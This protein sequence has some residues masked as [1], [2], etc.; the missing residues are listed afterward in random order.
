M[1]VVI[2]PLQETPVQRRAYSFDDK[3]VAR[4][5]PFLPVETDIFF[6]VRKI[7]LRFWGRLA[8]KLFKII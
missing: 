8:K 5:H 3:A 4:F 6:R 2:T 1:K 7:P